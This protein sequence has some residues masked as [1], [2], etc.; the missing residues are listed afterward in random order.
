M[1]M[2]QLP[3]EGTIHNDCITAVWAAAKEC[4]LVEKPT[5]SIVLSQAVNAFSVERTGITATG[6]K[7]QAEGWHVDVVS[8]IP[9]VGIAQIEALRTVAGAIDPTS[10]IPPMGALG[11]RP[12]SIPP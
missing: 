10:S 4:G 5:A 11:W 6:R 9:D 7:M 12:S 3:K 1:I 8:T 2:L